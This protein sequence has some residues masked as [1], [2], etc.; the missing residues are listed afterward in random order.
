M[1]TGIF[2]IPA[3]EYHKLPHM[4]N[5]QL[6]YLAKSPAHL[7]NYQLFGGATTP[8]MEF[9]TAVHT[10]ILELEKFHETYVTGGPINPRTGK[11]YGRDT[12]KFTSWLADQPAGKKFLSDEEFEACVLIHAAVGDHT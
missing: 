9:G 10:R 11:A 5:S 8:E 3:D 1:E 7:R 4:S 12:D 6:S 2:D